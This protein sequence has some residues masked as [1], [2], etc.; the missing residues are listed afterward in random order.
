M[1]NEPL[2]QLK[3]LHTYV[4]VNY[5]GA[6][7]QSG[8]SDQV[9]RNRTFTFTGF[10]PNTGVR[11]VDAVP[12]EYGRRIYS[13]GFWGRY[14]R[15]VTKP[16]PRGQVTGWNYNRG[17]ASAATMTVTS[18]GVLNSWSYDNTT[19]NKAVSRLYDQMR[20]TETNLALSLAE[21]RETGH[22]FQKIN[23]S[24]P[25]LIRLARR[26]R[27]DFLRNPSKTLSQIWLDY[28]YGW[29]AVVRDVYDYAQLTG[30]YF[31]G[32]T[33]KAT[34]TRREAYISQFKQACA[35]PFG[36]LAIHRLNGERVWKARI[37]V[38]ARVSNMSDFDR[39][40]LTS[41]NPVSIAWELVPLSFVF[42]W[43]FDVGGY[44]QNMESALGSGL[45]FIR[46]FQTE[47][48][49]HDVAEVAVPYGNIIDKSG[50][51]YWIIH[52]F[53]C[54]AADYRAHKRRL[55]LSGFPAGRRPNFEVKLGWQRILSAA[56]L[57]RT[58]LLGRVK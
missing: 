53:V 22:A 47:V 43:F 34:A 52:D 25:E 24:L 39:A 48:Y 57:A 44:L 3:K 35:G 51:S 41:L 42:D 7:T 15:I 29:G 16:E 45:T 1:I 23:K 37:H 54:N 46:G 6:G 50:S 17:V 31:D 8:T 18:Q 49:T 5:P 32:V 30:R 9:Y 55:K 56:A 21:L 27:R 36:S 4:F 13:Q 28:K 11:Y 40:R 33:F 12:G 19:L 2:T 26:A 20:D 38:T 58:I 10:G 14:D